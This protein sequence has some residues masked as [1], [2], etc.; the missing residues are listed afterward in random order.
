VLAEAFITQWL[1]LVE[2]EPDVVHR[3]TV[4][5]CAKQCPVRA[6]PLFIIDPQAPGTVNAV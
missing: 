3:L 5:L 4:Q 2:R 6:L 1:A